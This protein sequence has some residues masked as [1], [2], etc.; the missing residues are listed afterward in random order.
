MHLPICSEEKTMDKRVERDENLVQVKRI[1]GAQ[2]MWWSK[3]RDDVY[4]N[5]NK[6][7]D[8]GAQDE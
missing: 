8:K 7:G 6:I 3:E 2:R 1:K 5:R 4:D